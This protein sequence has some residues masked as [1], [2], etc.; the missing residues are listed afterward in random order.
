MH[1]MERDGVT[2]GL[3]VLLTR[4]IPADSLVADQPSYSASR[5]H[6]H[7]DIDSDEQHPSKKQISITIELLST[8][9]HIE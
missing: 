1:E 9:Y 5:Y 3:C 4:L 6:H 8:P 7:H 2:A